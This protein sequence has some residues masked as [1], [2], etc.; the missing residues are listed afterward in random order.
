ML[1]AL[2]GN[3]PS[4][5]GTVRESLTRACRELA[6]AGLQIEAASRIY[7]TE[8]VGR[9][10]QARYLN[11]VLVARG[12][13]PPGS[14]LRLLKSM[15][16]RAGRKTTPPMRPRPLDIDVL[17]YGGRR[18]NWPAGRRERGRLILPHPHV[19]ARAFVLVPLAEV[20]PR[21]VHPGLG[22]PARTLLARLSP[23]ARRGVRGAL[24]FRLRAC[25]KALR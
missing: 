16:R 14:L 4:R 2:G 3:T 23:Q 17:D 25:D 13:V 8:A 24:D 7:V 9:G 12:K 21:W 19:H 5:W 11:A 1:L 10:R 18:L 15:E 6:A 22:L 20:A